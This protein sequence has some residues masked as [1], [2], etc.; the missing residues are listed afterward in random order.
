MDQF[1]IT[2]ARGTSQHDMRVFTRVITAKS[3]A[4]A[5][6]TAEALVALRPN[7]NVMSVE[8]VN[9]VLAFYGIKL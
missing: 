4:G 3:I 5:A 6:A 2:F 9:P 1:K 7:G 8:H